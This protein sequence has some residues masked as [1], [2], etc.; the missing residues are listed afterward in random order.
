M[1]A[2]LLVILFGFGPQAIAQNSAKVAKIE[3]IEE[4]DFMKFI[5][6]MPDPNTVSTWYVHFQWSD[7]KVNM[8]IKSSEDGPV[9]IGGKIIEGKVNKSMVYAVPDQS[10]EKGYRLGELFCPPAGNL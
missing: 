1:K 3:C 7:K 8:S 10:Y 9:L 6:Y 2:L 5:V 4:T